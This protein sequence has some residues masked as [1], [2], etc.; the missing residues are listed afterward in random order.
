MQY[1]VIPFPPSKNINQ[2]LQSIV[3]AE[4]IDGWKYEN[5]IYNN[6]IYPGTNGCFGFGAKPETMYHVGNVVFSKE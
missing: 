4:A 5:H 6:Y 1:K 2:E 3:N